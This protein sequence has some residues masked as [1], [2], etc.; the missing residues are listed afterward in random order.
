MRGVLDPLSAILALSRPKD[1]NPC[2]QRA[3]VFDGKGALRS[4]VAGER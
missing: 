1:G 3:A 2:N 4:D